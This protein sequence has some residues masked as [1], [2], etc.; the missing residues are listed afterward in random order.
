VVYKLRP[1]YKRLYLKVNVAEKKII[2][3][4]SEAQAT[5]IFKDQ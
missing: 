3:N 5:K 2:K 4:K 1:K